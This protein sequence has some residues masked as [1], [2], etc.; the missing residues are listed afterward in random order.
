MTYKA[1]ITT[2]A[3]QAQAFANSVLTMLGDFV[4]NAPEAAGSVAEISGNY[5]AQT[6]AAIPGM[7]AN[8]SYNTQR[9]IVTAASQLADAA[10][11]L[12]AN[13]P[14][15]AGQ[16]AAA[17][18]AYSEAAVSSAVAYLSNP[19]FD[20]PIGYL[21]VDDSGQAAMSVFGDGGESG[22]GGASGGWE[23][24]PAAPPPRGP[25]PCLHPERR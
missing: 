8:A 9:V 24:D 19:E 10:G 12:M 21:H 25:R 17:A 18:A 2:S 20:N 7:V 14:A 16:F 22:G 3:T 5:V 13:V 15:Y 6:A 1:Y 4:A 11:N 23:I